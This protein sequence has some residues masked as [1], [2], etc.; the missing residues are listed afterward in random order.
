MRQVKRSYIDCS[1]SSA[2][3][4]IAPSLRHSSLRHSSLPRT[5][6]LL[7]AREIRRRRQI[8]AS[9]QK[10][11]IACRERKILERRADR[12]E[13]DE[14]AVGKLNRASRDLRKRDLRVVGDRAAFD[15]FLQIARFV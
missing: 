1:L 10:L 11:V 8:L 5:H 12:L 3:A 15:G 2:I 6:R 13:R 9:A 7:Q 4:F 14:T